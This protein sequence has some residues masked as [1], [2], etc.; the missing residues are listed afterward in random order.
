MFF[1]CLVCCFGLTAFCMWFNK[2]QAAWFG[3]AW[4]P[5]MCEKIHV[6]I[7]ALI[8]CLI[9]IEQTSHIQSDNKNYY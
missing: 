7:D 1:H 8:V 9:N 6:Y 3:L 4:L 2:D 5:V